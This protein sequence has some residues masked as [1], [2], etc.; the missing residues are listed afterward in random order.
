MALNNFIRDRS[1]SADYQD[2][3][4]IVSII[5]KDL[6]T[7]SD[8]FINQVIDPRLPPEEQKKL[9]EKNEDLEKIRRQFGDRPLERIILYID[10]LDRCDDDKVLEVLQA[11]HLLMAFPLFIV[12]VGVDKRCVT[13]ALYNREVSKYF[14]LEEYDEIKKDER[15]DG[16]HII[17]PDEYLEKIFQI[18]FQL[19]KPTPQNIQNMIHELLEKDIQIEVRPE[20][21]IEESSTNELN[22]P[23]SHESKD[24]EPK[25]SNSQE[26]N[27]Q[28]NEQSNEGKEENH[29]PDASS[30]SDGKSDI[31]PEALRISET[32]RE[33]IEKISPL[34]GTT[35][36]TIK[37]FINMYR[38]IRAHENLAS[39][40]DEKEFLIVIFILTMHLGVYKEKADALFYKLRE[41][42]NSSLKK[43]LDMLEGEEFKDIRYALIFN[44]LHELLKIEAGDF[45]D[46]L[47]FIRRFSFNALEEQIPMIQIREVKG[48]DL[49]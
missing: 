2:Q 12:V 46:Y 20:I 34:I 23:V 29:E 43:I 14:K 45:V 11:V 49:L 8:L 39:V 7:L 26:Q 21:N 16:I 13:N 30:E 47:S 22:G 25:D 24:D 3:L 15:S 9:K 48:K 42:L 44:N 5:R 36:R 27:T 31:A 41:N 10:D 4:G 40:K 33:Y 17:H 28:P 19:Q 37:R 6:E 35:P 1:M 32:E 38:L 18:P